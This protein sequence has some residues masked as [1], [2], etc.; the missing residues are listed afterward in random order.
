LGVTLGAPLLSNL[1]FTLAKGDRL[2]LVA[3][4]GRGKSTLLRCLAGLHEPTAGEVTRARGLPVGLAEQGIPRAL[5]T[6][7]LRYAVL[8]TISADVQEDEGWRVDI[9]LDDL[10]VPVNL[11]NRPLSELSGGWQRTAL[12]ART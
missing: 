3:A 4:N 12:L 6:L 2:G 8:Q 7:P 10:A 1:S 11:R 5:A 9:M